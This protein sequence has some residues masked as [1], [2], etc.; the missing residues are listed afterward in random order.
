MDSDSS[1]DGEILTKDKVEKHKKTLDKYNEDIDDDN[2]DN[3]INLIH[4]T[5]EIIVNFLFIT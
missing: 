4:S 5:H 2:D 3:T 1:S